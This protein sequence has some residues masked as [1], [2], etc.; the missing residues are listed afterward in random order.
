MADFKLKPGAGTG[1]K[2]ILESQDG[3]DVLTTSDSGV[4]ITAPTIADLS[5]VTGTLPVGV[6]GG[7]G[8]T[9]S[10]SLG[11]VTAGTYNATIGSSATFPSN[12][13]QYYKMN[14]L[15]V[16]SPT[17]HNS[18]TWGDHGNN[19]TVTVPAAVCNVCDYLS[20]T[21]TFSIALG[22][23]SSHTDIGLRMHRTVPSDVVFNDTVIGQDDHT[24]A[25]LRYY[26]SFSMIDSS[27]SNADHTYEVESQIAWGGNSTTCGNVYV[28]AYDL[29]TVTVIGGQS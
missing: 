16:A 18:G 13:I 12:H 25:T 20:I 5:N 17:S 3:T 9:G 24:T 21:F 6:I 15:S 26:L 1:N 19:C 27:L 4:A 7:A 8:L 28:N 22:P 14:M 10:T 29:G 11:T 2:L 23:G